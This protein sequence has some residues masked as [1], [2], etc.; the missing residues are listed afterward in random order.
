MKI[1][2]PLKNYLEDRKVCIP[3]TKPN[4]AKR[5]LSEIYISAILFRFLVIYFKTR[6]SVGI[7]V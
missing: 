3:F 7:Y 5:V 1:I 2:I 6:V 4:D